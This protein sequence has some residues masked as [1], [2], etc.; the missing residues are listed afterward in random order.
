MLPFANYNEI[1]HPEL[2]HYLEDKPQNTIN[3]VK[4]VFE[5]TDTLVLDLLPGESWNEEFFRIPEREKYFDND[6]KRKYLEQKFIDDKSEIS[7]KR[8]EIRDDEIISYFEDFSNSFLSLEVGTYTIKL[9][10]KNEDFSREFYII[11]EK[12]HVLVK[13]LD[14]SIKDPNMIWECPE[15]IVQRTIHNDLSWDEGQLGY[16]CKYSR[17]PDV[18]NVALW[19][20]LHSPWRARQSIS[21]DLIRPVSKISIA[22]LIEQN[23]EKI[24][25]ILERYGLFCVGCSSAVGE[26]ISD[27]CEIHG[28]SDSKKNDLIKELELELNLKLN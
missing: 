28:F 25:N 12:G 21:R 19:K 27:A 20:I 23:G 22:D 8:Q 13:K 5:G 24:S 6:F 18:Y 16:W 17:S 15:F 7:S 26:N 3:D 10:V 2:I 4:S 1:Y 14:S 11:F 9:I